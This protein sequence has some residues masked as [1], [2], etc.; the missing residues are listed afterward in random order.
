MEEGM[1]LKAQFPQWSQIEMPAGLGFPH[2][3]DFGDGI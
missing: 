3:F 2:G 1:P